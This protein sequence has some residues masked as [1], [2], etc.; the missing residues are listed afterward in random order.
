MI[1]NLNKYLYILYRKFYIPKI[2]LT[3]N[4]IIKP[5]TS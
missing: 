5:F 4:E 1:W 2:Q 3:I